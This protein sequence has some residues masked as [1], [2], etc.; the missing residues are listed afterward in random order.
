MSRFLLLFVLSLTLSVSASEPI[1]LSNDSNAADFHQELNA[2]E[3]DLNELTIK[4]EQSTLDNRMAIEQSILEIKN[5][6]SSI[7]ANN[8]VQKEI[9]ALIDEVKKLNDSKSDL[10]LDI[11]TD[12]PYV[13]TVSISIFASVFIT[14][15][16]LKRDVNQNHNKLIREFRQK[17]VNDF[18]DTVSKYVD[19]A[20][21][22]E[23]FQK[24]NISF[25]MTRNILIELRYDLDEKLR[26]IENNNEI[27]EGHPKVIARL[28]ANR[29][30]SKYTENENTEYYLRKNE[31][32]LKL[33]SSAKILE[34]KLLL[35]L[36]PE[37]SEKDLL[38]EKVFLAIEELKRILH[39]PQGRHG[40]I[41]YTALAYRSEQ[42]LE[43]T[44]YLLKTE[45]DRIKNLEDY[46]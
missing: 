5:F 23:V 9:I 32:Y 29:D 13:F 34:S 31:E 37:F 26:E 12:Y 14:W 44:R 33:I 16:L 11:G 24:N 42:L 3:A 35:L 22:I 15:L 41:D 20:S 19:I 6:E 30:F 27:P 8:D 1:Q 43:A 7:V 2:L 18:R 40:I 21:Q 36:K 28:N 46:H 10:E 17:W 38:D 39:S 45:W 4:F 25:Y